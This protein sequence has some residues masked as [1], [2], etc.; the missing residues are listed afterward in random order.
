MFEHTR[1]AKWYDKMVP[2]WAIVTCLVLVPLMLIFLGFYYSNLKNTADDFKYVRSDNGA[3]P[4]TQLE[5]DYQNLRLSLARDL[6][7]SRAGK[8]VSPEAIKRSFDI[9]YSRLNVNRALYGSD[10]KGQDHKTRS[11]LER[12]TDHR[13]ALALQIDTLETLSE[14]NLAELLAQAD[15]VEDDIRRYS[16]MSLALLVQEATHERDTML[17]II[18]RHAELLYLV[19]ALLMVK[20]A[21]TTLVYQRLKSKVVVTERTA[22]SLQGVIDASQDA[23]VIT[24]AS[25]HIAAYNAAAETIFGYTATEAIGAK[26]EELFIPARTRNAHL[27]CIKTYLETGQSKWINSGRHIMAV[28]DKA[29]REFSVEVTIA[30]SRGDQDE[31]IFISVLRDI[32]PRINAEEKL[33]RTAE[34]AKRDAMAKQQFLAVMSHEMRTPLQGVL[35]TFDLLETDMTTPD[36][37]DLLTLGKRSGMKALEQINNTLELARLSDCRVVRQ[38]NIISPTGLLFGLV[39]LLEPLLLKNG[40]KIV[41]KTARDVPVRVLGNQCLFTS[42]F[43]NLLANANKFTKNGQITVCVDMVEID[44]KADVQIAVKDTGIGID[45]AKLTSIFDDFSTGDAGYARVSEGTGLGLGIV[46]RATEKMGGEITVESV[47]GKGSVFTFRCRFDA[48]PDD[49][50]GPEP[51]PSAKADGNKAS[52]VKPLVLVVDDNETNRTLIGHML[53]RLGCDF[54]LAEDG[55]QAVEKCRDTS[56][57][58]ILMDVS[59]PKMDGFEAA[60]AIYEVGLM[61]GYMVCLTAHASDEIRTAVQHAGMNE[62]MIKPVRLEMMQEL[63]QRSVFARDRQG[64]C[65]TADTVHNP[66][67]DLIET[68]GEDNLRDLIDQFVDDTRAELSRLRDLLVAGDTSEAATILHNIN[69]NAGMIGALSLSA[70]C[71]DLEAAA[72]TGGPDLTVTDLDK[73]DAL[74]EAF[75]T[76]L[77]SRGMGR[78]QKSSA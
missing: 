18:F 72:T 67:D 10:S 77:R 7:N 29:G 48:A 28:C 27:E 40:N 1:R 23:V 56:Y 12:L 59:M 60:S 11:I 35:A 37:K 78:R 5:V 52:E 57:D 41:L 31:K 44:G 21:L 39:T 66:I 20:M 8:A 17:T 38:N 75:L 70:L 68:L 15:I 13:D 6:A 34:I 19:V 33:R 50:S 30:S 58:L 32:S 61:Q 25:G 47:L 24:S 14:T 64:D 22:E 62:M 54:E 69:G 71:A 55:M 26:M 53:K 36:Q 16:T 73:C 65:Q 42:V 4:I 9:Y 3:W 49:V 51:V 63:L 76:D 46:K 43:D 45:P 2:N 74:L